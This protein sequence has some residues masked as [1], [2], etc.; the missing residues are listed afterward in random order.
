MLSNQSEE[1]KGTQSTYIPE[2]RSGLSESQMNDSRIAR[3]KEDEWLGERDTQWP[4][5]DGGY[6]TALVPYTG[7]AGPGIPIMARGPGMLTSRLVNLLCSGKI[8]AGNDL[9]WEGESYD[10]EVI[11]S[12][13]GDVGVKKDLI[14][15]DETEVVTEI[16]LPEQEGGEVVTI[17]KE[18]SLTSQPSTSTANSILPAPTATSTFPPPSSSLLASLRPHPHAFLNPHFQGYSL[19]TPLPSSLHSLLLPHG[20]CTQSQLS[21]WYRETEMGISHHWVFGRSER[22]KEEVGLDDL[23]IDGEALRQGWKEILERR[24]RRREERG[25]IAT[26]FDDGPKFRVTRCSGCG[27]GICIVSTLCFVNSGYSFLSSLNRRQLILPS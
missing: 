23:G 17:T 7:G 22:D 3:Q 16:H 21:T 25:E 9:G 20:A 14:N 6:S 19:C 12:D 10:W 27:V 11:S 2:Q 18:E 24:K 5:T 13:E 8:E 15:K 26:D 4:V 1:A